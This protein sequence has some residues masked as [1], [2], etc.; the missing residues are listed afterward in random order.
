MPIHDWTRVPSGLFHHFHQQWSIDIALRLN[1]G[2]LPKGVSALVEQRSGP[3]E[4]DVLAVES[5]S[6]KARKDSDGGVL[7]ATRPKTAMTFHTTDQK[8][9]RRANRIAVK[10]HLGRT[11]AIIEIVSPGNKDT[12]SA[13]REFVEKS[14]E[15]VHAGIHVLVADLFP[16]G[17]R[18]PLGIHHAIW[19]ELGNDPFSF[20]PGQDRLL[21]SYEANEVRVAHVQPVAL[22]GTLPDMPLFL[23]ESEHVNVPLEATYRAAWEAC[24][25]E[26]RIAVATGVLPD[27][28]AEE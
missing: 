5:R 2:L 28:D 6:R 18:D 20:P 12:R 23:F 19:E 16:P 27:P 3:K 15:F 14:V 7:T 17:P 11:I 25:E 22:G 21:A 10:H 24:P 26:M 8:Y 13:L 1:S 4:S 9:A